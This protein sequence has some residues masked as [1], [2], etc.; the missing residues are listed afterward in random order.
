[1]PVGAG[2]GG[3]AGNAYNNSVGSGMMQKQQQ[4]MQQTGYGSANNYYYQQQ[5]HDNSEQQHYARNNSAA[6]ASSVASNN[7]YTQQSYYQQQV[8][9]PHSPYPHLD[10]LAYLMP[11]TAP[12]APA[13]SASGLAAGNARGSTAAAGSY[14]A[15]YGY[16]NS[17][18]GMQNARQQQQQQQYQQQASS[19]YA[20]SAAYYATAPQAS[21][22]HVASAHFA[23]FSPTAA[24]TSSYTANTASSSGSNQAAGSSAASGAGTA[25]GGSVFFYPMPSDRDWKAIDVYFQTMT[26]HTRGISNRDDFD[27]IMSYWMAH[28]SAA[29]LQPQL[30]KHW[31]TAHSGTDADSFELRPNEDPTVVAA[32]FGTVANDYGSLPP[33]ERAQLAHYFA[34]LATGYRIRGLG[35]SFS[36][37]DSNFEK[38]RSLALSSI[39]DPSPPLVSCLLVLAYY[40]MGM[41][42]AAS[43]SIYASFAWRL[44]RAC[45]LTVDDGG[46]G[47]ACRFQRQTMCFDLELLPLSQR[48]LPPPQPDTE[49]LVSVSRAYT[50]S[51]VTGSVSLVGTGTAVTTGTAIG[52]AGS[53]NGDP[54]GSRATTDTGISVGPVGSHSTAGS[55]GTSTSSQRSVA[56]TDAAAATAPAGLQVHFA[57]SQ[58]SNGQGDS[59]ASLSSS[60]GSAPAASGTAS[61]LP[62]VEAEPKPVVAI[63]GARGAINST[64]ARAGGW[65]FNE[66]PP[67]SVLAASSSSSP[68]DSATAAGGSEPGAGAG[69]QTA[70]ADASGAASGAVAAITA[71]AVDTGAVGYADESASS[72]SGPSNLIPACGTS[73]GPTARTGGQNNVAC[74]SCG[75]LKLVPVPRETV[76]TAH[77]LD[78]RAS[79]LLAYIVSRMLHMRRAA[80][81]RESKRQLWS[82]VDEL[83]QIASMAPQYGLEFHP[84]RL[85]TFYGIKGITC[86]QAGKM[87]ASLRWC[88]KAVQFWGSLPQDKMSHSFISCF[89]A[90]HV[91]LIVLSHELQVMAAAIA[92][93]GGSEGVN[94]MKENDM[95]SSRSHYSTRTGTGFDGGAGGQNQ[96]QT[97]QNAENTGD[98]NMNVDRNNDDEARSDRG[99]TSRR[100][101]VA[102]GDEEMDGRHANSNGRR[103]SSSAIAGVDAREK[104]I[105][106]PANQAPGVTF[107]YGVKGKGTSSAPGPLGTTVSPSLSAAVIASAPMPFSSLN[108]DGTR[109]SGDNNSGGKNGAAGGSGSNGGAEPPQLPPLSEYR[110]FF[111][112]A[113]MMQKV[114]EHWPFIA[115]MYDA[116]ISESKAMLIAAATQLGHKLSHDNIEGTLRKESV[117]YDITAPVQ[118]DAAAPSS[119]AGADGAAAATGLQQ[120]QGD[121]SGAG[122]ARMFRQDSYASTVSITTSGISGGR[123][124]LA[125]ATH[126]TNLK[127]QRSVGPSPLPTPSTGSNGGLGASSSSVSAHLGSAPRDPSSHMTMVALLSTATDD[128][129]DFD[130]ATA[131]THHQHSAIGGVGAISGGGGATAGGSGASSDAGSSSHISLSHTGSVLHHPNQQHQNDGEEHGSLLDVLCSVIRDHQPLPENSYDDESGASSVQNAERA[132]KGLLPTVPTFDAR[133]ASTGSAGGFGGSLPAPS[134]AVSRGTSGVVQGAAVPSSSA[135]GAGAGPAGGSAASD[136][137][138]SSSSAQQQQQQQQLSHQQ[139]IAVQQHTEQ[140]ERVAETLAVEDATTGA[141]Q[142]TSDPALGRL[143]RNM[144]ASHMVLVRSTSAPKINASNLNIPSFAALQRAHSSYGGGGAASGGED[145]GAAS[146]AHPSHRHHLRHTTSASVASMPAGPQH[147]HHHHHGHGHGH[148]SS[149]GSHHGPTNHEHQHHHQ[150]HHQAAH[151]VHQSSY[152]SLPP[153]DDH[154]RLL[155]RVESRGYDNQASAAGNGNGIGAGG[156]PGGHGPHNIVAGGGGGGSMLGKRHADGST[157]GANGGGM[158]DIGLDAPGAHPSSSSGSRPP[159]GLTISLPMLKRY[160][161][162]PNTNYARQRAGSSSSAGG[163]GEGEEGGNNDD[164]TPSLLDGLTPALGL[165]RHFGKGIVGAAPGIVHHSAR[166]GAVQAAAASQPMPASGGGGA[167][168]AHAAPPLLSELLAQTSSGSHSAAAPLVPATNSNISP[169]LGAVSASASSSTAGKILPAN[170]HGASVSATAAGAR[171]TG[172][173]NNLDSLSI[174]PTSSSSSSSSSSRVAGAG[175][176]AA[177][178]SSGGAHHHTSNLHSMED[179]GSIT[180]FLTAPL[181]FRAQSAPAA[182]AAAKTAGAHAQIHG[183]SSSSSSSS[184]S[185]SSM[186]HNS[187]SNSNMNANAIAD[188]DVGMNL[189]EGNE[190]PMP[191]P[192]FRYQPGSGVIPGGLNI[193]AGLGLPNASSALGGAGRVRA[194]SEFSLLGGSGPPVSGSASALGRVVVASTSP[195]LP[196]LSINVPNIGN[197]T[198]NVLLSG[199]MTAIGL[200][201]GLAGLDGMSS[202]LGGITPAGFPSSSSSSLSIGVPPIGMP[203]GS[204]NS[205]SSSGTGGVLGMMTPVPT[206]QPPTGS[207]SSGG[208]VMVLGRGQGV[209]VGHGHGHQHMTA[210]GHGHSNLVIG[211]LPAAAAGYGA[212]SGDGADQDDENG[213][214]YN[215]DQRVLPH[216]NDGLTPIPGQH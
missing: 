86:R 185:T 52:G 192:H 81:D 21:G 205:V 171:M 27:R 166:L 82:R 180:P 90:R 175:S 187:G 149:G 178:G 5:Q 139:A 135:V 57:P 190:T 206:M 10:R 124:A 62:G 39:D 216:P 133:S 184:G 97:Q 173:S 85:A 4:Q 201:T 176:A 19:A 134:A 83:V 43:A 200:G 157:S 76:I 13:S 63:G 106:A 99:A 203:M 194:D 56:S 121:A 36:V 174:G 114:G 191:M 195:P 210:H 96:N 147:Q 211:R 170:A 152:T 117:S 40:N 3:P 11:A 44:A 95:S 49:P 89:I 29:R 161:T 42:R 61:G 18:S 167:G 110:G 8:Q 111:V 177:G 181:L 65:S 7:N 102:D 69:G 202:I 144:S 112:C 118:A 60:S 119:G 98:S 24:Q 169:F 32:V 14:G 108:A 31:W 30:P 145:G 153:P 37:A 162:E 122:S 41:G 165:G 59:A 101:S 94:E 92:R 113:A 120:Q 126:V 155:S 26:P 131:G 68:S 71:A 199:A 73:S 182:I 215:S 213:N 188:N 79:E 104:G 151:L 158:P 78:T 2:A 91:A 87:E 47:S 127:R 136:G 25:G 54:R 142:P 33:V 109:N 107:E 160:R 50:S 129:D 34:M 189:V 123:P 12:A 128:D 116:L 132:G 212:L 28:R 207:S 48:I 156:V 186:T 197:S 204:V 58:A 140:E 20:S 9:N 193:A 67:A 45:G 137:D 150:H 80:L 93:M 154:H 103:P 168:S 198:P 70:A 196:S 84:C 164:H 100:G 179:A 105:T 53:G 183:S 64:D 74:S 22:A 159:A 38:A 51:T 125:S 148:H 55:S 72:T 208:G 23:H 172:Q 6:S 66:G 88:D 209:P 146:S 15:A 214:A 75:A 163:L 141:G 1:M 35:D 115:K 130:D 77:Y 17:S 143:P 138:D 46:L 16:D